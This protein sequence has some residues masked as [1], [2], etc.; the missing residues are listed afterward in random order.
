MVNPRGAIRKRVTNP[1]AWNR[2]SGSSER[3]TAASSS[4]T[5]AT[6][7]VKAAERFGKAFGRLGFSTIRG[8]RPRLHHAAPIR[9]L[10]VHSWFTRSRGTKGTTD[11]RTKGPDPCE[12]ASIRGCHPAERYGSASRTQS[13][14]TEDREVRKELSPL[15]HPQHPRHPRSKPRSRSGEPSAVSVLARSAAGGRGYTQAA[16]IRVPSCPFVVHPTRHSSALTESAAPSPTPRSPFPA[17]H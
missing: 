4:A 8:E 14:G 6:S 3:L 13:L 11:Q 7:A 17:L 9:A 12:S 16:P 2:R 15:P 1:I 10:R 5:S